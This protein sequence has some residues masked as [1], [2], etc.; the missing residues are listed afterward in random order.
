MDFDCGRLDND[1]VARNKGSVLSSTVH[2][3]ALKA[4]RE[5]VVEAIPINPNIVTWQTPHQLASEVYFLPIT[6]DYV[7]YALEKERLDGML[8][9][10]VVRAR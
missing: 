5:E 10:L 6:P 8:L 4:S 1:L 7:A 9:T 2:S 3:Q